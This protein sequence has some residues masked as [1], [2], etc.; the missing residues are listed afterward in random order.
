MEAR[1]GP[2]ML[3]ICGYSLGST[4]QIQVIVPHYGEAAESQA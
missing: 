1:L 3:E 4:N 2:D